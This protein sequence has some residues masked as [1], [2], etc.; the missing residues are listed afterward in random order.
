MFP[1][2]RRPTPVSLIIT[3]AFT[4][5]HTALEAS[6]AP[7]A[8][9]IGFV[10]AI[11][12]TKSSALTIFVSGGL[13]SLATSS[14]YAGGVDEDEVFFGAEIDYCALNGSKANRLAS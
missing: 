9:V 4:T 5:A 13:S 7:L 8:A 3:S 11:L 6:R 2:A 14:R 12:A 10:P 1:T